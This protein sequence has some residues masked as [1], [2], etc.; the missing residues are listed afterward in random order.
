MINDVYTNKK[1]LSEMEGFFTEN[2]FI[3]LNEFLTEEFKEFR[4]SIDEENLIEI[5]EP[6]FQRK[7]MLD[8]K[9]IYKLELI[10]LIEY[11][12]S[13]EFLEFVEDITEFDLL[14]SKFEVNVYSHKDFIILND[15]TPRNESVSLVYDLSDDFS[16]NMG[17]MLTYTTKEEEIFYLEPSY[18]SLSI[19]YDPIEV[20]K[21]LKYINNKSHGLKIV[22]IEMEFT[23]T[24]NI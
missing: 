23:P 3:Q 6:L 13:K 20:M 10:K 14:L 12:K 2:G 21:Y 9:N 11:F 18:N 7:K 5:Y 24:E 17:G 15:E 22:R 16:E 1:I 19:F 4:K 8:L